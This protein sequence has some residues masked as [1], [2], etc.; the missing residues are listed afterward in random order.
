M[1]F[2]YSEDHRHIIEKCSP[3]SFCPHP[4]CRGFLVEVL[5]PRLWSLT[6]LLVVPLGP[7]DADPIPRITEV[8]RAAALAVDYSF[9]RSDT[10][11]ARWHHFPMPTRFRHHTEQGEAKPSRDLLLASV[12][13]TALRQILGSL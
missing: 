9:S 12:S 3:S 8:F 2:Q 4:K 6:D 1:P 5:E 10:A 7:P 11:E 13:C